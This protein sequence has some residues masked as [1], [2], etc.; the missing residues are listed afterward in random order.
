MVVARI[1]YDIIHFCS[2]GL[3]SLF[4]E[5]EKLTAS[6]CNYY[7]SSFDECRIE[8]PPSSEKL[9]DLIKS[10]EHAFGPPHPDGIDAPPM[11]LKYH[12]E[13]TIVNKPARKIN[14]DRLRIANE[15]FDELTE[16]GFAEEV[17]ADCPFDSP[18][19]L[20][21]Y[22]DHRKPRLTGEYSGLDGV[23]TMSVHVEANL[24]RISDI[25]EFLGN[26]KFI[27]I[28]DLLRAFWQLKICEEDFSKRIL[29]IPH[30]AV[31][32]TRAAFG[33]KNVPAVFQNTM[34]NIFKGIPNVFIYLDDIII[35]AQDEESSLSTLKLILERCISRKVKLGN[36]KCCFVTSESEV[37][38]LARI[39]QKGTLRNDQERINAILDI[40]IP[41]NIQ[42]LRSF[43]GSINYIRNWH[44]NISCLLKSLTELLN[45]KGEGTPEVPSKITKTTIKTKWSYEYT[46]CFQSHTRINRQLHVSRS[47][48]TERS[49]NYLY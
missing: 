26:A 33:L 7:D 34:T 28:L 10:K 20:V 46:K 8:L 22:N 29:E 35:A 45:K 4:P 43:I 47:T 39:F 48:S 41:S 3:V 15:I 12:N 49:P 17:P 31:C 44:P 5:Q 24:P 38:I 37:K 32:F 36:K 21:T 14:P 40:P 19:V 25:I 16:A 11:S 30:R 27:A 13:D 6:C 2:V 9:L 42:D 18:I 1:V 23:N